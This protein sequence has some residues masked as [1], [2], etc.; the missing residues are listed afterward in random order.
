M[1]LFRL[2]R[3]RIF[4]K[5]LDNTK[6]NCVDEFSYSAIKSYWKVTL[7][8]NLFSSYPFSLLVAS[9][10]LYSAIVVIVKSTEHESIPSPLRTWRM[11]GGGAQEVAS[12]SRG[13]RSEGAGC[14]Y[15][16]LFKTRVKVADLLR[17]PLLLLYFL[18]PFSCPHRTLLPAFLAVLLSKLIVGIGFR[19]KKKPRRSH[20]S[21]SFKSF[22]DN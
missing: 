6:K 20:R 17:S 16:E 21:L 8:R 19:L 12:W 10:D 13:R 9:V 22:S 18:F 14:S 3:Y 4:C 15:E 11:W 7:G 1:T 2:F 5:N